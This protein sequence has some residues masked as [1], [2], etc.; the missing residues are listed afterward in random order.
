MFGAS[1]R[2]STAFAREKRSCRLMKRGK[3]AASSSVPLWEPRSIQDRRSL[4]DLI[5]E[6]QAAGHPLSRPPAQRGD[7]LPEHGSASQSRTGAFGTQ[8]DQHDHDIYSHVLP[9]MQKDAVSKLNDA[10]QG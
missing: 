4:Q 2:G 6:G 1:S 10:L 5:E 3:N 7:H 8:P 9:T